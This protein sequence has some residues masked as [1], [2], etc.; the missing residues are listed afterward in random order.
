MTIDLTQILI[1]VI[2]GAFAII[3]AVFL[4]WLQRHMKDKAAAVTLA[5]AISN[6]LGAIQQAA[7]TG[8]TLSKPTVAVPAGV[9]PQLAIGVQYVLDHAGDE[10]TW[11]GITP[12]S[13]AGKIDA[14]QGLQTIAQ[15]TPTVV[16]A[17]VAADAASALAKP[18]TSAQA[19]QM[20]G[21]KP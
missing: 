20:G 19:M 7:T 3:N 1:T 9:S 18:V 12:A 15:A 10:A 21:S 16:V 2:G 14:K 5:T 4:A 13:I 8:V 6:S 11:L 17:P